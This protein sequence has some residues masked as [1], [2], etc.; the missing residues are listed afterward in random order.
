MYRGRLDL[1]SLRTLR[2]RPRGG[3]GSSRH[4]V[5]KLKVAS[6]SEKNA[7]QQISSAN[8]PRGGIGMDAS[9]SYWVT[10]LDELALIYK[11]PTERMMKKELDHVDALGRAF[12]AAS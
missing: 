10:T 6:R 8:R 11:R 1:N 3:R 9:A 2:C 4:L 5:S 7:G 12:I